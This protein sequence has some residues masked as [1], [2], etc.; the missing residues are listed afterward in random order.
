MRIL[1]LKL[2]VGFLSGIELL[3]LLF[4]Q[5]LVPACAEVN[6]IKHIIV[7]VQENHTF[8]NYFGT[9]PGANG[10]NNSIALPISPNSSE[11]VSP[12]HLPSA[13]PPVDLC[14]ER[15]CALQSYNNGRMDGFVYAEQY[16]LTMGYFD[17][18]E[19]PYYWAYSSEFVLADNF[20]SS[21]LGPSLP[22]HIYLL[23][24]QSG[25]VVDNLENVTLDFPC[26]MDRLDEKGVTWR[27]YGV[28]DIFYSANPLPAFT[29]FKNNPARFANCLPTN[30]FFLDVEDQKLADVTWI[31]NGS[32]S[33]HPDQN[34]T[35]GQNFV[36]SL[37]NTVMQSPYW[38]ST[39][40][41]ITWDD[42]GGWYDH[43]APPQVDAAGLGFRVPLIVIS[44]YAKKGYIDHYLNDLTSILKF[45]ETTF[46]LEPLTSRD[47]NANLLEA[48][49]FKQTPREPL[50]LPG[51]YVPNRY[52][53]VPIEN[54]DFDL[55]SN[56]K[57][58][59][60]VVIAVLIVSAPVLLW[61]RKKKHL[62]RA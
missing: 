50:V 2:L 41:F 46:S 30:Q 32:L 7:I 27:Y 13:V 49:D 39:A 23:A 55:I 43:V 25:G 42:Y 24:G 10:I 4:S 37:V 36:V 8:D 56:I 28:G 51:H 57:V 54:S 34:V 14:H 1:S 6:P 40:I 19:I 18:N 52:P 44:P 59:S 45:I 17:H 29:S 3:I 26:I 48:F 15:G 62:E 58:L 9:Y 22:N 38:S 53:L 35:V 20:F 60:A 21:V 5:P 61:L 31:R 12:Y 47:E 16:P 11:T 33:E